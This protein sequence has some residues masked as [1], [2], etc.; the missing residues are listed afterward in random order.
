M[1]ICRASKAPSIVALKNGP[2]IDALR[3]SFPIPVEPGICAGVDLEIEQ[4]VRRLPALDVEPGVRR[5]EMQAAGQGDARIVVE[6]NVALQRRFSREHRPDDA[7]RK[8]LK[9]RVEIERKP[10]PRALPGDDDLPVRP[11]VRAGGEIE[12]RGEIVQRAY[13]I[14]GELHRR[15]AGKIGEMR[16][17]AASRLGGIHVEGEAV[18]RR[19]IGQQRF[20]VARGVEP[21]RGEGKVKA[22]GRRSKGRLAGNAEASRDADDRLAERELLHSELLDDHLDRQLGEDRPRRARVR[23][24]SFGG[25][26]AP[27]KLHVTDRELIDLEPPAE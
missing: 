15:Q 12:L 11:H 21:L 22:L 27:Q 5:H 20:E 9:A 19:N 4:V 23:R 7:R 1:W 3:S 6:P 24:R 10:T 2:V 13:A 25:E 18:G 8:S 26:R 17:E 14:E 16:K